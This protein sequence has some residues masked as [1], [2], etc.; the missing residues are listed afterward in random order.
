MIPHSVDITGIPF[1]SKKSQQLPIRIL[2]VAQYIPRK[3]HDLLAKAIRLLLDRGLSGFEVRL[4]GTQDPAW[5]NS[6]IESEKLNDVIQVLGVLKGEALFEEFEHAD[7]F[8]LTSRFDTFAVVV[9]EAAAF[10]LPLLIS[11]FA[12][13]SS[14]MVQEGIN[15]YVIDPYKTEELAD[16]IEELISQPEKRRLMGNRSRAVAELLCASKLGSELATWLVNF[17]QRFLRDRRNT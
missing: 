6:I 5:L 4:V 17:H 15:G 8:V 3:G 9:H 11:K 10:G 12:E 13:S 1:A 7:F 2:M 16:R 14:L